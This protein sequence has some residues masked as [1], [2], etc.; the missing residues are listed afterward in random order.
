MGC[1]LGHNQN[2]MFLGM[3]RGLRHDLLT[4][5]EDLGVRVREAVERA[6]EGIS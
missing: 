5:E 2:E 6:W 3:I 1:Y 4:V